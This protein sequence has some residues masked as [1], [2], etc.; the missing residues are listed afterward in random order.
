MIWRRKESHPAS[1]VDRFLNVATTKSLL[2]H[3]HGGTSFDRYEKIMLGG[4]DSKSDCFCRNIVLL[5]IEL[6][7]THP[8]AKKLVALRIELRTFSGLVSRDMN[9]VIHM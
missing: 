4:F 8:P 9:H 6:R 1:C 5:R 2:N 7:T 3:G